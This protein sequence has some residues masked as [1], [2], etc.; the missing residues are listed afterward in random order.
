LHSFPH[1]LHFKPFFGGVSG[2]PN[3][4]LDLA[5]ASQILAIAL[6]EP[7]LAQLP[8]TYKNLEMSVL[9]SPQMR[10]FAMF[11]PPSLIDLV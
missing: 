2:N 6:A 1:K 7:F 10:H 8:Q 9:I 3:S 4:A 11:S 5:W